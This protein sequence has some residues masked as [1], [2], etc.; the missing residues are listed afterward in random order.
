LQHLSRSSTEYKLNRNVRSTR[1][2]VA[3]VQAILQADVGVSQVDG[4][5]IRVGIRR[6]GSHEDEVE[7]AAR[8]IHDLIE[9]GARSD[10]IA[11]LGP[12]G[13]AGPTATRLLKVLPETLAPFTPQRG[14]SALSRGSVATIREF[15]GLEAPI[16]IL[17]DLDELTTDE[18][19]ETLLYVGMTRASARLTLILTDKMAKR[20]SNLLAR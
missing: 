16:C 14:P 15:R 18:M 9:R 11:V 8:E 1:E 7:T 6:A 19:G 12:T 10:D 13:A 20:I 5:G 2:I 3:C 4:Y 17:V